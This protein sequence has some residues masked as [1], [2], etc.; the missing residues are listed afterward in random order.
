[1]RARP[2]DLES[3]DSAE[4]GSEDEGE[5]D[6]VAASIN[7]KDRKRKCKR[8]GLRK[9]ARRRRILK[10]QM[11]RE[12]MIERLILFHFFT[13]DS[14]FIVSLSFIFYF[15]SE[16]EFNVY[17]GMKLLIIIVHLN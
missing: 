9:M 12:I 8:A 4:A 7:F 17:H 1:M 13:K 11:L 5:E 16:K 3:N 15:E 10:F 6:A 14:F 2:E